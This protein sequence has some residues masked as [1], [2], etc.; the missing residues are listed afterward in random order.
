LRHL[1]KHLPGPRH[2]QQ[3]QFQLQQEEDLL[4]EFQSEQSHLQA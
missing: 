1:T 4:V 3:P 2:H